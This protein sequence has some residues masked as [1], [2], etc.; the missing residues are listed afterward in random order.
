MHEMIM[1]LA[2]AQIF[3]LLQ[4]RV[5]RAEVRKKKAQRN[6][7]RSPESNNFSFYRMMAMGFISE[8]ISGTLS[9]SVFHLSFQSM[10]Y[11]RE[12]SLQGPEKNNASLYGPRKRNFF[13]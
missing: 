12:N 2:W 1:I 4:I 3:L 9:G 7:Y 10:F 11:N 5:T 13:I 6:Q 8:H